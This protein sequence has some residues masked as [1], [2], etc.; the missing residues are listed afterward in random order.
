MWAHYRSER[1]WAWLRSTSLRPVFGANFMSVQSNGWNVNSS[2]NG[3]LEWGSPAGGHRVRVLL[4]FQR[5]AVLFAQFFLAKTQNFGAVLQ[6]E[7]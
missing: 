4:E 2:L 7:F 6:F 1:P 5:G 3:G